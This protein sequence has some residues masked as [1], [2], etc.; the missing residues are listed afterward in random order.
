[1]F[2]VAARRSFRQ[3]HRE[4]PV[5]SCRALSQLSVHH[6]SGPAFETVWQRHAAPVLPARRQQAYNR[7][8]P[9]AVMPFAAAFMFAGKEVS[10]AQSAEMRDDAVACEAQLLA[11]AKNGDMPGLVRVYEELLQQGSEPSVAAAAG[12]V[13]AYAEIGQTEQAASVA[14]ALLKQGFQPRGTQQLE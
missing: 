9:L 5:S 13:E 3:M 4:L 1:M 7:R 2:G 8:L 10:E 11:Y 12:A 14:D 6:H